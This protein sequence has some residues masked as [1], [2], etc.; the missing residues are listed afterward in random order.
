MLPPLPIAPPSARLW[1]GLL[2]ALTLLG[3]PRSVPG[4]RAPQGHMNALVLPR[5]RGEGWFRPDELRGRTVLV[6]FFATW[7]F[8]CLGALPTLVELQRRYGD[9]GLTVVAVGMDLEGELVLEPFAREYELPF[10]LLVADER[11]RTGQTPFGRISVLPTTF[12][13]GRDGRVIA[14]FEGLATSRS[15]D[16]AVAGALRE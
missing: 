14:A 8:P 16:A 11:I 2:L 13:L 7:C 1:G 4:P 6:N 15:L 9:E 5:A 12:L 3:C 10:P